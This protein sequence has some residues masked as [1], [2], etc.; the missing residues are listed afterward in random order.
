[1]LFSVNYDE[2]FNNWI[3]WIKHLHL[4]FHSH[5][6]CS[7]A[8]RADGVTA[9]LRGKVSNRQTEKGIF[10]HVDALNLSLDVKKPRLSVAK[11]F[12]NNRILSELISGSRGETA[13]EKVLPPRKSIKNCFQKKKFLS[14]CSCCVLQMK[15]RI[16]SWE[17]MDMKFWKLCSRNCRRSWAPNSLAS[18]THC[19]KMFHEITSWGIEI[20]QL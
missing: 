18:E 13:E 9:N 16:C 19:S 4:F 8:L 10:L 14:L 20:R 17:R 12:N 5:D 6:Q 1:M 7:L 3:A 15:P 11:I 2:R